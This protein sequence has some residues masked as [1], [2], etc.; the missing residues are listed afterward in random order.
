MFIFAS[1]SSCQIFLAS[2][3]HFRKI[4]MASSKHFE[5]EYPSKFSVSWNLSFI[6]GYV[7]LLSNAVIAGGLAL[8]I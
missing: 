6:I 4:Q 1:T 2:S 3:K 8:I 7:V 5:Y